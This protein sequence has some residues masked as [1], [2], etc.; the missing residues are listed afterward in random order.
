VAAE[1]A[2]AVAVAAEGAA[3]VAVAAEGAAVAAAA[4]AVHH[5]YNSTF[6]SKYNWKE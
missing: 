4:A 2:A 1:G 3:A 6:E 5:H